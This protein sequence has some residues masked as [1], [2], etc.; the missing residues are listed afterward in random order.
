MAKT[1][2]YSVIVN[3]PGYLPMDDE[4]YATTRK[5]YARAEAARVAREFREDGFRV[6]GNRADGYWVSSRETAEEY[7]IEIHAIDAQE[8]QA[9][10]NT[11][12]E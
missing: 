2:V 10:G 5:D 8:W 12:P 7:V 6:S 11:M 4:P 3:M 1:T 9:M